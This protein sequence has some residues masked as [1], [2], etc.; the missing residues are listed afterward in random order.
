VPDSRSSIAIVTAAMTRKYDR[1]EATTPFPTDL[2]KE[3][4]E[5][6]DDDSKQ[7]RRE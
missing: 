2:G 5:D 3:E 7:A 1:V 6:D 4:E